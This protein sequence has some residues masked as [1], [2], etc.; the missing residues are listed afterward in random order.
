MA[1]RALQ[2]SD[3]PRLSSWL[4]TPHVALWWRH[5]NDA[6][7]VE[8]D[9]GPA[10]DGRDPTEMFVVE[11]DGRDIGLIQRYR[12]DDHPRWEATVSVGASPCP[13]IGIDYLIG[14]ESR[15]GQGLG[16][17]MISRF[18]DDTWDRH[19]DARAVVVA[20][21]QANRQSWRALEK[22]GFRREWSGTL[23]SDDPSDGGPSHLYVLL[24][25]VEPG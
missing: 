8:S 14:E 4:E 17:R 2:R 12:L 23:D 24:R 15:I 11:E 10:V 25:P 9:F 19:P 5:A 13:A 16:A 3:F 18:V 22:A 7:T 1:F 6:G 20:V 21:Q